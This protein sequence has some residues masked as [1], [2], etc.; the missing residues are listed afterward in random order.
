MHECA[1]IY[2]DIYT[3]TQTTIY[4]DINTDKNYWLGFLL[5][6]ATI[7][8][9]DIFT[10]GFNSIWISNEF[11]LS[12]ETAFYVATLRSFGHKIS[13]TYLFSIWKCFFLKWVFSTFVCFEVNFHHQ[14]AADI[15]NQL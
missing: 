10:V 9:D 2:L 15:S 14:S 5:P 7:L 13:F 3:Y 1:H 8:S 11:E 6:Y 12:V 4:T